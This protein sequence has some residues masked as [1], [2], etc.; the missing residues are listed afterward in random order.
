MRMMKCG[1]GAGALLAAVVAMT[2]CGNNLFTNGGS[3]IT[4]AATTVTQTMIT[5]APSDQVL[6][7]SLT[8]DSVVLTDSAGNSIS[9]LSKP[10]TIEASHLNAIKEPF[11]P[12]IKL[13]QDTYVSATITVANPVVVY[14]DPTTGKAVK[15]TAV[16]SSPSTTVT[17]T[18]PIVVGA[19]A[20]PICFDLLV[21]PS[22]AI[23]GTT[24][25]VTPTFNVFQVPLAANPTNGSNGRVDQIF[26]QVV[27]VSGTT[28]TIT[29]PNGQ[30]LAIATDTNTKLQDIKALTDL[31]AGELVDVD[32]VQ[33]STGGVLALR[34]H[35]IPAHA[36]SLFVGPVTAVTGSPATSFT[37]LVRQP[38][39][40]SAPVSA[41]ATTQTVAVTPATTFQLAPTV[42]TLPTLPFVPTFSAA[43]LFAGENVVV[44]ADAVASATST[45]TASSV[46]LA[47]QTLEG[48]VTAINVTGGL[49]VYTITL[50]SGSALASLTGQTTAVVYTNTMTQ[51]IMSATP[52]PGSSVRFVGL[53]FSDKGALRM[54]A[55]AAC[56]PPG[57]APVQHH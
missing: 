43:T 32:A 31:T 4:S 41:T 46:T 26:G 42:G 15:A 35:L 3:T 8:V 23:S 40:P 11:L 12:P 5:D 22:V 53:L 24:V 47:P 21:G 45:V 57:A 19:Q 50:P 51:A 7:L 38:L 34:I 49:T 14:V 1:V 56:D 13:P 29:L 6:A 25:T 54:M 27:S 9:V 2:G 36:N 28:L 48:A 33:Q 17:F 20:A 30:T 39:G 16:L 10:V 44:A 52:G 55:V 37:Q 18:T